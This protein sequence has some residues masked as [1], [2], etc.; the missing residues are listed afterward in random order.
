MP[1]FE[2]LGSTHDALVEEQRMLVLRQRIFDNLEAELKAAGFWGWVQQ[3]DRTPL[4]KRRTL[5]RPASRQPL[6]TTHSVGST[7]GGQDEQYVP[8]VEEVQEGEW[9]CV[10]GLGLSGY[11]PIALLQLGLTP[12]AKAEPAEGLVR[13]VSWHHCVEGTGHPLC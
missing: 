10:P 12:E 2:A 9:N 7:G 5:S 6:P 4:S 11:D 8:G 3:A 13:W 1:L